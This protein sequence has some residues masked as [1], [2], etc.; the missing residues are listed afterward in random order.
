MLGSMPML[1]KAQ[2][3]TAKRDLIWANLL[4][5]SYN[6]WTDHSNVA[7]DDLPSD[8]YTPR[9]FDI[10]TCM[11]ARRWAR[12]YR[13]FLTFDYTTW[14]SILNHMVHSGMN[15]VII[16]LGDGVK[17][18]S[19][20]EIAV[21]NAW[22][23]SQLRSEVK[24][25]RNMGLEPIPKLN[26]ATTHDAWL[27]EYSRMVSTEKYYTVCRNLIREVID[28]FDKPRFFHLG[29]DE[30]TPHYQ[31][32][33]LHMVVRQGELWWHDF[34]L[35]MEEVQKHNSRPWIWS[36]YVWNHPEE[37]FRK[38]PTSV[39]QSNWYYGTS[40]GPDIDKVKYYNEL[41]RRGYDQV[42]TGSS[43]SNPD[44]FRLTVEYCREAI[45][46]GTL[47]GFMQTAWRPTLPA[48]TDRHLETVDQV[49]EV[50]RNI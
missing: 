27:G 19:H 1:L 2:E 34:Y 6:M 15:M 37:F 41:S 17:Y 39:L 42:P 25:I 22:T 31:R 10:K 4:H 23:V 3:E 35:L 16:D 24:K 7:W 5:L 21:E 14:T 38:M 47:L 43:H 13:P 40:F 26:F 29:M 30:E 49:A 11:D 50:I 28:I 12:G 48:C 36:D 9:D 46:P 20:P 45:D 33:H 32:R 44:N 8:H 18:D